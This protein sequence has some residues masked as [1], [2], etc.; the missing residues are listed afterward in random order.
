[1]KASFLERNEVSHMGLSI[2]SVLQQK[3]F[4]S[5]QEQNY[6]MRRV[7]NSVIVFKASVKKPH[8]QVITER[9][10]VA[11]SSAKLTGKLSRKS[12]K[13]IVQIL[14]NWNDTI[15]EVNR[16]NKLKSSH[17]HYQLTMLTLTLS[18]TQQHSD[19]FIKR[20]LLMP[21]IMKLVRANHEVCYLWKAEPQG[22][23][24]IHFHIVLDRYFDKSWLQREWNKTQESHGYHALLSN[25]ENGIGLPS[26]R[27]EALKSVNN[28]VAYIAK[29]VS[30]NEGERPISGRLWGCSDKL[31]TLENI[32]YQIHS[33]VIECV[34]N[35]MIP[36]INN[37]Y[38]NRYCCVIYQPR[39]VEV[40]RESLVQNPL[41][42]LIIQK[43][44][45][46]YYSRGLNPKFELENTEWYRD[47]CREIG[48]INAAYMN[49]NGCLFPDDEI[50]QS[51]RFVSL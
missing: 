1:M 3:L 31:K 48:V 22:N 13:H 38:A 5:N 14:Q 51:G 43:N 28:S 32:E 49:A 2:M 8:R 50:R 17:T 10:L 11:L 12:Q 34:L 30:K 21:F 24:N 29:Y 47:V 33:S 6:L 15:E 46:R 37:V 7:A 41:Y 39:N 20:F 9:Q 4:L 40:I 25:Y 18:S 45:Q 35:E 16:K 23:G 19:Q 27:V 26:T 44:I 42:D 36:S